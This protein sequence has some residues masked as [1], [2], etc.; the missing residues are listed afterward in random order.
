[1]RNNSANGPMGDDVA[2]E[3]NWTYHAEILV[4][5]VLGLAG[6]PLNIATMVHLVKKLRRSSQ[7][8]QSKI[9]VVKEEVVQVI[10]EKFRIDK[11][12]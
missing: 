2:A 3:D 11:S 6:I 10:H 4:L 5:I 9:H 1:M 8:S 12:T 7:S